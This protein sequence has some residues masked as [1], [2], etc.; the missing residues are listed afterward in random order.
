MKIK[1]LSNLIRKVQ[2]HENVNLD[3]LRAEISKLSLKNHYFELNDIQAVKNERGPLYQVTYFNPDLLNE[4][5]LLI[6]SAGND[7]KSA[8]NQNMSH[9]HKVDGSF[10]LIRHAQSHPQVVTMDVTGEFFSP[11]KQSRIAIVVENR[12]IF[13]FANRFKEFL[14]KHTHV[15]VDETTDFIFGSGNE[16]PNSYHAKFLQSYDHLYLCLDMDLGGLMT[17]NNL[18]SK[19]KHSNIT[20]VQPHDIKD[21]LKAVRTKRKHDYLL[22]ISSFISIANP[23]LK[24]F[25]QLIRS[26]GC[27]LEQESFL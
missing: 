17:A 5:L 25:A 23:A 24:P 12:Q 4:I 2:L 14:I 19:L 3:E 13:L 10:L 1:K 27:T 20:F 15:P 8:A 9:N 26:M 16:L 22:G 18:M 11:T 6:S 7:R 21:R